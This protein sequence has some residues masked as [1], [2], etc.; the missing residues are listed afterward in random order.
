[1]SYNDDFLDIFTTPQLDRSVVY[2]ER[3]A[4]EALRKADQARAERD[5]RIKA[6][7]RFGPDNYPDH[8]IIHFDYQFYEDTK[9]YA[10]AAIKCNGLWYSTGPRA[11]KAYTWAQMIEWWL[12]STCD[13]DLHYVTELT[14]A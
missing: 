4:D 14:R 10:Y 11:P 2:W 13:V 3:K 5:A 8:A 7:E 6:M 1:M 12:R 9:V